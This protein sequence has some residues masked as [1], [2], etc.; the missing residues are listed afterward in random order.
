MPM[1]AVPT[2]GATWG[3]WKRR[4][5]EDATTTSP[6]FHAMIAITVLVLGICTSELALQ[7]YLDEEP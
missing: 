3:T 5:D 1:T 7:I 2:A 4:N 6:Y